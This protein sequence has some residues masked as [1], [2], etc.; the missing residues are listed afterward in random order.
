[1]S[2]TLTGQTELRHLPYP[3]ILEL[4]RIL[5]RHEAWKKLMDHI[6]KDLNDNDNVSTSEIAKSRKYSLEH[7]T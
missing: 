1:M 4:A 6:P 2:G 3:K 5:D 7:I